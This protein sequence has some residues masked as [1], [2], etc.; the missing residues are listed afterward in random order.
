MKA[1]PK[2]NQ[3]LYKHTLVGLLLKVC[4]R[5]LL[6]A[7]VSTKLDKPEAGDERRKDAVRVVTGKAV[8]RVLHTQ[9]G[10]HTYIPL[11]FCKQVIKFD[12]L[13]S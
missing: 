9:R 4:P 2:R 6:K 11:V 1:Q 10:A 12:F 3:R 8:H 5:L 7:T 13:P